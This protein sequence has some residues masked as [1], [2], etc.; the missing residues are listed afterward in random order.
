VQE[1]VQFTADRASALRIAICVHI[2]AAHPKTP[3]RGPAGIEDSLQNTN[4][5]LSIAADTD[6]SPIDNP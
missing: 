2:V 3:I 4:K 5:S 6:A 1:G